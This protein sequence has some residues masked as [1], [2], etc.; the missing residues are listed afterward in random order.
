MKA[1]SSFSTAKKE[2][3]NDPKL[4]LALFLESYNVI[5]SSP[6]SSEHFIEG[7]IF[8]SPES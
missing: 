6:Y 1:F 4:G 2:E 5:V 3:G 7:R 8:P